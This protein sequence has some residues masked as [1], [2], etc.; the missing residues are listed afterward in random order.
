MS[1][2]CACGQAPRPF[3]VRECRTQLGIDAERTRSGL[4]RGSAFR[5]HV[6]TFELEAAF[7]PRLGR[8]VRSRSR[9]QI[10]RR[11][12]S[13]TLPHRVRAGAGRAHHSLVAAFDA[14][15]PVSPAAI[16]VWLQNLPTWRDIAWRAARPCRMT[17]PPAHDSPPIASGTP[18]PACLCAGQ[19]LVVESAWPVRAPG[20]SDRWTG[21]C[22]TPMP[23]GLGA[24]PRR[25]RASWPRRTASAHT[26][27]G[28]G[29]AGHYRREL[30]AAGPTW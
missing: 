13:A 26:F 3:Y 20:Q 2:S 27:R 29:I 15:Y 28:R 7:L 11:V 19:P 4:P 30:R 22:C 5:P 12:S 16:P 14:A 18:G 8:P 21:A 23:P 25:S 6:C 17:C 24:A 9:A 10:L 1:G